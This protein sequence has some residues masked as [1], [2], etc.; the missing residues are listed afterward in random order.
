MPLHYQE[1]FRR[2]FTKGW[3]PSADDYVTDAQ[4]ALAGGAAGWC[5][6]NGDQRDQPDQKPRRSFDMRSQRLFE[7][8]D[9]VELDALKAISVQ[10]SAI[11]I[12]R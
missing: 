7:Q 3:E 6:H 2:G 8:L 4:G 5:L 11:S 9:Q 12:Q 1:P 10:R